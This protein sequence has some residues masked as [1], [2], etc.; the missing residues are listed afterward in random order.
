[1]TATPTPSEHLGPAGEAEW[2]RLRR[3]LELAEG[4]WLG[5]VF[6]PSPPA[7]AVLRERTERHLRSSARTLA[8]L[9]PPDPDEL[10]M[11]WRK[12]HTAVSRQAGCVW[13]EAV[14]ADSPTRPHG[15]WTSAWEA[16][17]LALNEQR[18]TLRRDLSGGL[19]L[20]TTPELKPR[21]RELASDFWSIRSLVIDVPGVYHAERM[22]VSRGLRDAPTIAGRQ[23]TGRRG[24]RLTMELRDLRDL[25]HR[26]ERLLVL[27][28]T[29]AAVNVAQGA[30]ALARQASG[31]RRAGLAVALTWLSRAEEEHGDLEAAADHAEE[32]LRIADETVDRSTVTELWGRAGRL[33]E[34]RGDLPRATAAYQ[35]KVALARHRLEAD[36]GSTEALRELAGA[37]SELS[38][39]EFRAGD[40]ASATEEALSLWRRLAE[41]FP[42]DP[43]TLRGLSS[44]LEQAAAHRGMAGDLGAAEALNED[45]LSLLQRLGETTGHEPSD[46]LRLVRGLRRLGDTYRRLGHLAAAIAAYEE[47]LALE[48]QLFDVS[49]EA[50]GAVRSLVGALTDVADARREAGDAA[51]ADKAEREAAQLRERLAS[52]LPERRLH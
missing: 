10:R 32:A 15:P 1:M 3:Y 31:A 19:V 16:L 34:R 9:Q 24:L 42:D 8:L 46:R 11:T 4:F 25:L 39:V 38:T 26:V 40:H 6:T 30:V 27:E 36:E 29:A 14:R 23:G 47:A 50:P 28:D 7:A 12:L 41:R 44:S 43:E 49:G 13:I 2:A 45:N 51:G 17:L 5:F 52:R 35:E 20:V 48:R 33:A 18:E 37:L 21:A 22:D